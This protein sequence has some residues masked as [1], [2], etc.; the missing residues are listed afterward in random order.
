MASTMS[1]K[2]ETRSDYAVAATRLDDSSS[3]WTPKPKAVRWLS[4]VVLAVLGLHAWN[5]YSTESGLRHEPFAVIPSGGP[6]SMTV[7]PC[8]DGLDCGYIKCVASMLYLYGATLISQQRTKGPLQRLRWYFK[9]CLRTVE[10]STTARK[11]KCHD[12]S[13]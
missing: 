9:Y 4:L 10:S 13:R 6:G 12:Q 5:H 3:S 11:R 8:G 1:E 7:A 2:R